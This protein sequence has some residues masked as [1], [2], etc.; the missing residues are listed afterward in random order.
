MARQRSLPVD[1]K[2]VQLTNPVTTNGGVT[3]DIVSMKSAHKAWA[4]FDLTQAVGHAT[5]IALVQA[6]DVGG[7]TNKAG[8]S[9]PIWSNEDTAATDTLVKQVSAASYAVTN[10]VKHKQVVI[11]IDPSALD[12]NGGYDCVYFTVSD[13]SQATNFISAAI[14]LDDRFHQ[15]TPPAA[16]T[17]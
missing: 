17:D 14:Y 3:T 5:S 6:T 1:L 9:V 16:I 12:V 11:E 13:S 8:P 15:A 10:N 7:A 4:V 2:I